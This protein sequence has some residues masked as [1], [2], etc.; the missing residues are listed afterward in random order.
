MCQDQE[1]T[2]PVAV[3]VNVV[4][5]TGA[6]RLVATASAVLDIGG[7]EV[8]IDN[9]EVRRNGA[10]GEMEVLLPRTRRAGAWVPAVNLPSDLSEAIGRAAV[11][12]LDLTVRGAVALAA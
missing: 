5:V 3:T 10:P 6:G 12:A 11:E 4:P 2:L 9:I 7:I 8:Q 1:D